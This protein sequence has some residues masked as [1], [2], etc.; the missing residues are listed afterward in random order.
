VRDDSLLCSRRSLAI[1]LV[2]E[3]YLPEHGGAP[4]VIHRFVELLRA[5]SHDVVVV[6][7]RQRREPRNSELAADVLVRS[8]P[9]P[10]DRTL[11]VGRPEIARLA[12][13]W[14]E[15]RPDLVHVATQG[16][17]GL[18]ALLVARRRGIPLSTSFHTSFQQ[19]AV[20]YGLRLFVPA[21]E[22]YLRS[23]H[24]RADLTLVPSERARKRLVALGIERLSVLGRG[25]DQTRFA[26]TLRSQSLRRSLG[27]PTDVLAL[28][29]VGRLAPEKNVALA[30]R[31]A[32]LV[33]AVRPARLVVVG[34][35]PLRRDLSLAHP[36]V[37][38]VGHKDGED[39]ARHY[40]S[41]DLF[42]FPSR[43]ETFGN[44]LLEAM[45]SGLPVVAFDDAAAAEHI[46][47]GID[48]ITVPLHRPERFTEEAVRLAS[49]ATLRGALGAAASRASRGFTWDRIGD[50][51]SEQLV[52]VAERSR[53][54]SPLCSPLDVRRSL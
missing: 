51:L 44:V 15:R 43:T 31:T 30:I 29:Y 42:L 24:N 36:D 11:R 49:N 16:P 45:A 53:S 5:R 2:T 40:A 3:T 35:G 38:F 54:V 25:V 37:L 7:P 8:L 19:F 47:S 1:E 13:R 14:T 17:L 10:Y 26:P 23:F 4:R 22:R 46:R 28:L 32:R 12:R 18:G 39:L 20:H 50:A 41:C 34:D 6:R 21:I 52:A 9:F 27:I 33:D 48:G